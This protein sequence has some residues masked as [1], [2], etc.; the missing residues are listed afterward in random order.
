MASHRVLFVDLTLVVFDWGCA[1][2]A[3]VIAVVT[4]AYA[5]GHRQ[6]TQT[7]SITI[8]TAD[9]E[10]RGGPIEECLFE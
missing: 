2:V 5:D 6:V 10:T 4:V 9:Q 1:S 3:S 8:A 7:L